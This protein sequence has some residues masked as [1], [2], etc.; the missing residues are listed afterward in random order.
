[1]SGWPNCSSSSPT[2]PDRAAR[3]T[4]CSTVCTAPAA[5]PWQST[6]PRRYRSPAMSTEATPTTP[7]ARR[8]GANYWKLFASATM[9]NL[10]DGLMSVAVLWVASTITRDPTEIA[11]VGLASRLPWLVFSLPAGVITDRYDR[12]VLVASTDVLRVCLIT[13]F[14]LVML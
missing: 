9:T 4:G 13:A 14:A 7:A 3:P 10:G 11:L 1:M 8:L 2:S 12:R 5:A 6:R